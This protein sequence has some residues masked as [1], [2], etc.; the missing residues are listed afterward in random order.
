MT[1][2]TLLQLILEESL[3]AGT[4]LHRHIIRLASADD[5]R[6]AEQELRSRFGDS[7]SP[8]C[9]LLPLPIA[10]A[11]SCYL[12]STER[13]GNM[14][15]VASI[16]ED[17]DP[18]GVHGFFNRLPWMQ[19][20][21]QGETLSQRKPY[22]PWGVRHIQ[23]PQAWKRSTGSKIKVGVI[24]TGVDFNHPDLQGIIGGGINLVYRHMLPLD[25]N[26]HG[27]HICGT[28]AAS[29][30]KSGIIGVAPQATL[31]A[32]KAFDHNGTSFVTD[33]IQGIDW[34]VRNRMH[35]INMSF[36]MKTSSSAL[37]T[38]VRNAYRAGVVIVA[39]S[40]N[41]G[42]KGFVDYP[43]RWPYAIA[44]GAVTRDNMIA[45][46]SNKGRQINIYA[47]GDTIFST[48]LNGKYHKLSGTSMATSHVSG[49][50]ALL[51]SIKPRMS[52]E[53]IISLLQKTASP[54]PYPSKQSGFTGEVNAA[55]TVKAIREKAAP[56]Y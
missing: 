19:Q 14:P 35:V 22:V 6:E 13:L 47:P 3:S 27:T 16:E 49:V 32:V 26:G 39:S 23:A 40:G 53:Q 33:I 1:N 4:G 10:N 50:V 37:E 34:C 36:G 9:P 12:R 48:W 38:A 42:K 56:A 24:D 20:P 5:F 41:E 29:G 30:E 11:F 45:P 55:R 44:V 15:Q 8:G 25:D 43:A 7:P 31:Y 46:F 17:A 54:L 2:R 21:A 18:A 52:I 28:I 51:L